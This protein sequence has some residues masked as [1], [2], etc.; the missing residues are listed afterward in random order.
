MI[1]LKLKS[2]AVNLQRF[3]IIAIL[4]V[5][6]YSKSFSYAPLTEGWWRTYSRWISEGLIPYKDFNLIVPP[7]MP[8]LDL[9]FSNIVGQNFL[10]LRIIGT[11]IQCLIGVFLYEILRRLTSNSTAAILSF[12]GTILIYSSEVVITFDYNYFAIL[13]LILCVYF[14]Q[15]SEDSQILRKKSF[16]FSVLSGVFL[17]FSFLVK[18]N[19]AFFLA[20]FYVI[21]TII[22]IFQNSR[23]NK[24][25][26]LSSLFWKIMGFLLP[27]LLVV[28]YFHFKNGL[29][30]MFNSLFRESPGAKGSPTDALFNWIVY[31]FEQYS[32]RRELVTA[33]FSLL[34]YIGLEKYVLPRYY[35]EKNRLYRIFRFNFTHKLVRSLFFAVVLLYIVASWLSL[36][37]LAET[38]I[39]NW[40]IILSKQLAYLII[41]HTYM[42]PVAFILVMIFWTLRR[43]N[44]KWIPLFTLCL[45][46]IWGA[47]TSGGLNW[48]ATAIPLIT[49]FAWI[50]T[51]TRYSEF[52]TATTLIFTIAITTTNYANWINSPYNWWGYRVPSVAS[53]TVTSDTGLT[54][55]LRTDVQT[56]ST[57]KSVE[58]HF[59]KVKDCQGG[60]LV[61]PH[62]PIFQLDLNS[63]PQRRDAVY[64]FDFASQ[65]NIQKAITEIEKNPPA[66]FAI[67]NVPS[68]VWEEHSKAFN[69][70][71]EFLQREMISALLRESA[72]GY[73]SSRYRLYNNSVDWSINVYTRDSCKLKK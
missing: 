40:W 28:L 62:M 24:S 12:L 2:K 3:S 59:Q 35:D 38:K 49:M 60:L 22:K 54:K 52:L 7:G 15:I 56:L 30:P 36:K 4:F 53:A 31:L 46:L 66:G 73:S 33:L 11:I 58:N 48:Y 67:V 21:F 6:Q 55:G 23:N 1:K 17:S 42:I 32:Y 41:P 29:V 71:E 8:Y 16:I 34:I 13:F 57:L 64:W 45:T 63:Q 39:D 47:G 20:F 19:F 69:G 37:L 9:F 14:W 44:Q 18:L 51:K 50:S 68:F 65:K 27:V 10:G 26:V 5:F 70:G 25:A 43:E 72:K 61:F